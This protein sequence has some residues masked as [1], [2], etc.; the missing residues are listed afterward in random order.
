MPGRQFAS[1][2]I[3]DIHD[4]RNSIA[5]D[6][7]VPA[8]ETSAMIVF[9]RPYFDGYRASLGGQNIQVG[10]DGGLYPVVEVPAGGR[11]RL[12]LEYRPSW[13]IYGGAIALTCAVISVAGLVVV[14]LRRA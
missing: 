12:V 9:S 1:A 3:S 13:L 2:A 11:G 10:S 8:G 14:A 5:A 7:E 6:I 4:F